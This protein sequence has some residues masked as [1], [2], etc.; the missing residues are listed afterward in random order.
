MILIKKLHNALLELQRILS[1]ILEVLD[2]EDASAER[3]QTLYQNKQVIIEKLNS[4]EEDFSIEIESISDEK[5]D[6]IRELYS[7]IQQMDTKALQKID[8]GVKAFS[9]N[10][11]KVDKELEAR[12]IY[13]TDDIQDNSL[14][15]KKKLEG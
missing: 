6:E 11:R 13:A 12:Y 4:I 1:E 7:Q 14:F 15:I 9:T 3:L 8:A 10:I 5:I 2:D